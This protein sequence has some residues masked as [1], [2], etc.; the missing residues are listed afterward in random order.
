MR[1][2]MVLRESPRT[3]SGVMSTAKVVRRGWGCTSD[4]A[5]VIIY[6]ILVTF[7]IL[8]WAYIPA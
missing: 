3:W 2:R 7:L 4:E 5:G 8:S 1:A 6:P